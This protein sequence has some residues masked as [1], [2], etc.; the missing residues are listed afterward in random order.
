M[1]TIKL[2]GFMTIGG[3]RFYSQKNNQKSAKS[4]EEGE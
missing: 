1:R 4:Y 3:K 2:K